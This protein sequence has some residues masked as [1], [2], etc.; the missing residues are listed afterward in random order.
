MLRDAIVLRSSH[1]RVQ[2]KCLEEGND[3]TLAKALEVGRNFEVAQTNMKSI[4]EE[5]TAVKHVK[6]QK[7]RRRTRKPN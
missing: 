1:P 6:S 5:D 7:D 4:T 2:E 3:L